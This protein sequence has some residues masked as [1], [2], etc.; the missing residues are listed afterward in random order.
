MGIF[1]AIYK[2]AFGIPPMDGFQRY[3]FVSPH[4]DDSDVSCGALI[5]RLVREGKDVFILNATDGRYGDTEYRPDYTVPLRRQEELAAKKV[6]GLDESHVVFLP[7]FDGG[8]YAVED[9]AKTIAKEIIRLKPDVVIA[10]DGRTLSE[11]HIDHLKVG[12]AAEYSVL[13]AGN[14]GI[15]QQFGES[16]THDIKEIAFYNTDKPNRHVMVTK[17]DLETQMKALRC[18]KSQFSEEEF[19]SFETFFKIRAI[20]AGL[21][22]GHKY[23]ESFRVLT[24]FLTHCVPEGSEI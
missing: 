23:A 11:C 6:Y 12:T 2:K 3:L 15:A 8:E 9:L 13:F 10:V 17:A 7:F 4:P 20:R 22:S 24:K 21:K 1:T 18:H 5:S 19:R 14:V 16:E